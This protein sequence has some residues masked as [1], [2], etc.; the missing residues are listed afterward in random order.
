MIG[1]GIGIRP[2]L[3]PPVADVMFGATPWLWQGAVANMAVGPQVVVNPGPLPLEFT[4]CFNSGP[5]VQGVLCLF[6]NEDWGA[7]TTIDL[8]ARIH[9]QTDNGCDINFSHIKFTAG[10][11]KLAC[12]AKICEILKQAFKN[13]GR[14]VLCSITDLGD[15]I[16]ITLRCANGGAITGGHIRVC[17]RRAP[18]IID[19]LTI[20]EQPRRGD[21]VQLVGQNLPD[22]A[23]DLCFVLQAEDGEMIAMENVVIP[24]PGVVR[25]VIGFVRPE[26]AGKPFQVMLGAGL[27]LRRPVPL[28]FNDT[29]A[30]VP[31]W[32]WCGKPIDV[33]AWPQPV[34]PLFAAGF[35]EA[36]GN[37]NFAS[38]PPTADGKLCLII[39]QG[40]PQGTNTIK[41]NAR[42]HKPTDNGYDIN[43]EQVR[44][45]G[46]GTTFDCAVRIC[47]LLKAAFEARGRVVRCNVTAD[48]QG[49]AK[50]TLQCTGPEMMNS[51][52]IHVEILP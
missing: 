43:F 42:I 45:L 9:K 11:S 50:I 22:K 44:L 41:V 6:L 33:V 24:Q 3:Q 20:P 13:R 35:D 30:I 17:V 37:L 31:P 51:G 18:M 15:R 29:I 4:R 47:S 8:S 28:E 26:A 5:P 21:P 27:G 40:W 34:F 14:P 2:N 25:G 48:A 38:G 36:A 19:D 1:R 39:N 10:G 16:K 23:D 49:N 12:A 46:G 7:N 32:M 52:M